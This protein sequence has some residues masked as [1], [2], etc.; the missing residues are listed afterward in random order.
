MSVPSPF[1]QADKVIDGM[2]DDKKIMLQARDGLIKIINDYS[3]YLSKEGRKSSSKKMIEM[4]ERNLPK[5]QEML[6][7]VNKKI[8]G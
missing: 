3:W 8:N 1:S 6:G 5:Y 7:K 2:L 4:A